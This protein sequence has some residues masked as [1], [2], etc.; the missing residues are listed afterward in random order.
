M[1]AQP[2]DGRTARSLATRA[3]IARAATRLF[4]TD[5]YTATSITR[6][7][8]EAGVAA[9]TVYNTCGT[10]AGLLKE[11]LDQAVAGDAEPVATLERPWVREALSAPDPRDLVRLQIRG[12]TQVM[13]RVAALIEV[14]RGAAASDPELAAL[15]RT[16]TDQ[17]RTVHTV[18][19]HT[20]AD[21][22][23]LRAGLDPQEAADT[24]L[25]LLSP[26]LYTLY[27]V[28]LGWSPERWTQW[29]TGAVTRQLLEG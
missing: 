24:L 4:T 5:G 6:V 12:T 16:N 13:E 7:A 27:T 26:E 10:K 3:R 21:R 22:G 15:W 29:A 1:H 11:A 2:T 19:A 20:L 9:Q 18:F 28:Q 17:R 23:A 25:G 14:L 8:E